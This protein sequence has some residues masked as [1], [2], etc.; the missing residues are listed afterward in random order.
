ML[1]IAAG[2]AMRLALIVSGGAPERFEYDVLARN[3]IAGRGYVYDQLGTPYRSFYAGLGY[4]AINLAVDRAFPSQ[5]RP[6]AIR[7][8]LYADLLPPA[9]F[10]FPRPFPVSGLAVPPGPCP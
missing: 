8:S 2:I 4:M 7:Q 1:T 3:V 6:M 10:Q 9:V 5:P